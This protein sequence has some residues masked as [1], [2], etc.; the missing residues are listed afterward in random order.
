MGILNSWNIN[1]MGGNRVTHPIFLLII[2]AKKIPQFSSSENWKNNPNLN[3]ALRK[4]FENQ[5]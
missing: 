1:W 4:F 3:S 2:S 5:N